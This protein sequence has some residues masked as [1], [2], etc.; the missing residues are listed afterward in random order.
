MALVFFG[1][2]VIL[3]VSDWR[4]SIKTSRKFCMPRGFLVN[5]MLDFTH[6]ERVI[7][8]TVTMSDV[9][10]EFVM[11]NPPISKIGSAL[12]EICKLAIMTYFVYIINRNKLNF[13]GTSRPCQ[14]R[15]VH[16]S[17][18][19]LFDIMFSHIHMYYI[20]RGDDIPKR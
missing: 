20:L 16:Y 12:S 15:K 18:Y 19:T 13:T 17:G 8:R 7:N 6:K 11:T 14:R 9:N 10:M 4:N 2:P 1:E 5:L 3:L